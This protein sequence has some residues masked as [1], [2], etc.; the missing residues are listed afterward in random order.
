MRT[1]LY[2]EWVIDGTGAPARTGHA[3]VIDGDRIAA[4][5]PRAEMTLGD[6]DRVIQCPGDTLLPGLINMHAHLS[7]AN[8]NAPFVPYMDA[9]SDVALALQATHN[10]HVSLESGV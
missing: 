6:S 5:A 3:V 9:H 1:V 2:P 4:V 7:L 10:V 8:D